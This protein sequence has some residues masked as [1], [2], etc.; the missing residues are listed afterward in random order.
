MFSLYS[1]D[2]Y[3]ELVFILFYRISS[4]IRRHQFQVG[5]PPCGSFVAGFRSVDLP[6]TLS[7][8]TSGQRTSMRVRRRLRQFGRPPQRLHMYSS[9]SNLVR[10]WI[11]VLCCRSMFYTMDWRFTSG[12]LLPLF[13]VWLTPI[14]LVLSWYCYHMV[15]GYCVHVKV[16][17]VPFPYLTTKLVPALTEAFTWIQYLSHLFFQRKPTANLYA[18]QD[19][20][21][22]I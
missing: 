19:Q 15:T 12:L 13:I 2:Y 21:L 11:H 6:M 20:V 9:S 10:L 7:S 1:T 17:G 4:S 16:F 22:C 5:G 14:V 18:C 3:T 8:P